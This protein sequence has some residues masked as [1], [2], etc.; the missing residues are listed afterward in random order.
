[1]LPSARLMHTQQP[2]FHTSINGFHTHSVF[3]AE[4]SD[5]WKPHLPKALHAI[6]GLDSIS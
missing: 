2:L 3:Q 5:I 1:M 4:N 6:I